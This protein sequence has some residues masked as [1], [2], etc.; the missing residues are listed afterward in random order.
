MRVVLYHVVLYHL[1]GRLHLV[2]IEIVNHRVVALFPA[3]VT[4]IHTR[5]SAG[6]MSLHNSFTSEKLRREYRDVI[7]VYH[8]SL[9]FLERG[10]GW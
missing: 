1:V 2:R 9:S 3:Y 6:I 4:C 10:G 8:A 5:V 7:T